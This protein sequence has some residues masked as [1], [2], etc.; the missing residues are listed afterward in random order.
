MERK[1]DLRRIF[2][3]VL[4]RAYEL[5][6]KRRLVRDI[7]S[8][9]VVTIE[10]GSNMKMAARL[11]GAMR[12]GSLVVLDEEP[13]GIV[14]ERDLLSKVMAKGRDPSKVRVSSV[15]SSPLVTI[16]KESTIKGAAKTMISGKGRLVVLEDGR[17]I[18]IVTASDLI[19][20]L[21]DAP[22]TLLQVEGFMTSPVVT[23]PYDT[24]VVDVA[25]LMGKERIG[26]VIITENELPGGIFTER[27]LLTT[28][29]AEGIDL[30]V[31]V[32]DYAS[33]PIIVAGKRITAHEAAYIM[34]THRIKRL[35]LVDED[36]VLVGIVTARDLVEAYS[37]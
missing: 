11:M 34:T 27:D 12:I 32:G 22:D 8:T 4:D 25:R 36:E 24:S 10:P 28:L 7:M 31:P 20:S 33:S 13:I 3:S 14:T 30:D 15:M 2:P 16:S 37:K 17:M 1:R 29:L 21:P 19:K 23:R 6:K 35:P 26:S 9:D 5:Y 18:G